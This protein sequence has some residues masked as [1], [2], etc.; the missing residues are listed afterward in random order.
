MYC[1]PFVERPSAT[2]WFVE[3]KTKFKLR[4]T[5]YGAQPLH[6]PTMK[7][8]EVRLLHNPMEVAK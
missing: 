7:K 5:I 2:N 1:E 4:K 8:T 6:K 3:P